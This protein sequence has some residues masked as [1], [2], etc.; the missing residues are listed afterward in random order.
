MVFLKSLKA[1][2]M[3]RIPSSA[4]TNCRNSRIIV[5]PSEE[6]S[7]S[8]DKGGWGRRAVTGLI[9]CSGFDIES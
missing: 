6:V 5:K 8:G 3:P 1:G 9:G 7:A 4:M 2:A